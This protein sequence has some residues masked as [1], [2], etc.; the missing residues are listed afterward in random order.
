MRIIPFRWGHGWR[1]YIW[2]KSQQS[3]LELYNHKSTDMT[4][5]YSIVIFLGSISL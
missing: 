5:I 3:N 1:E 4:I 2:V